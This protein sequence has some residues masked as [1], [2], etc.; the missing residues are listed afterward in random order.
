M[1]RKEW[2][3][4]SRH[5]GLDEHTDTDSE[6]N[7]TKTRQGILDKIWPAGTEERSARAVVLAVVCGVEA[8][9]RCISPVKESGTSLSCNVHSGRHGREVVEEKM[10]LKASRKDEG[11]LGG[12]FSIIVD[13]YIDMPTSVISIGLT[14][15]RI[16]LSIAYSSAIHHEGLVTPLH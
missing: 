5:N 10:K 2:N 7:Q 13:C 6:A 14:L 16:K 9:D 11:S 8:E 3:L 15:K 1:Y 4:S 12:A